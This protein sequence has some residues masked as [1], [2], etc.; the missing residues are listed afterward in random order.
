MRVLLDEPLS[1]VVT[2]AEDDRLK[3]RRFRIE[4]EVIAF[5]RIHSLR[6]LHCK[7]SAVRTRQTGIQNY[8]YGFPVCTFYES[9]Y[10]VALLEF[11]VAEF[12]EIFV[13]AP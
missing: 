7:P 3:V 8:M 5:L 13:V 1:V 11:D 9:M 12:V 2:L 6:A 10:Y 4:I